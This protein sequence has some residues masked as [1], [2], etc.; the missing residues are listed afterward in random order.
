MSKTVAVIGAGP[1][2]L[3]AAEVLSAGGAQVTVF[4]RM[5]SVGRKLLMAGRGGLNLT[6]SEPFE[7]FLA[8]YGDAQE[9][10]RPMLEAF[11]PAD[12]V[13]WANGLGQETF[14]GSSGRVFPK[15]MKASPLLRAWLARL[16][17]LGVR[18]RLRHDWRGWSGDG[19]L[20][21][22]TAQGEETLMADATVLALGGASWPRLGADGGWVKL[23]REKGIAV[24]DLKPANAGFDVAWSAPFRE[25]FA[26][27]PLKNI[28]LRFGTHAVRGEAV[29]TS[30]GLEGG[31]V[32]AASAALRAALPVK[33]EIDLR[34]DAEA[35]QLAS[36]L[37]RPRGKESLSNFLRKAVKL[38]PLE[39]NLL[40][41]ARPLPDEPAMLA[42]RIKSV[43]LTLTA[44]QPLAR[45]IST[46]GGVAFDAVDDGLM[47]KAVPGTYVVG[48]MLDWEAPTGGYLL[49]ACFASGVFAGRAI[50]SRRE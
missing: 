32:Y 50:L 10:L 15:A 6:H 40:R 2:G 43:P 39:I 12:L 25:R 27:Q 1:A 33:V 48:E 24:S 36:R 8:R 22:A 29:I 41:E 47:L 20:R 5:P 16:D 35:A 3:M 38:S 44:M 49:Q 18:F 19:V 7:R 46:A 37:A 31:V 26:G 42:A 21:F 30:Y 13:A 28:L 11:T 23:L 4:D 9:R 34:P 17:R 45:A 14:V